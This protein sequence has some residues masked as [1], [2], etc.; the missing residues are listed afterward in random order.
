MEKDKYYLMTIEFGPCYSEE[1]REE[2]SY[3]IENLR[4]VKVLSKDY[5]PFFIEYKLYV[6]E[7]ARRGITAL[8]RYDCIDIL[9]D[10]PCEE[11]FLYEWPFKA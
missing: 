8:Y 11:L 9:A 3:V 5:N 6:T 7:S 4:G 2:M 10:N 1:H